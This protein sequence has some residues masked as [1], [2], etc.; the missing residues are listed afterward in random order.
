[1]KNRTIAVDLAKNVSRTN[2]VDLPFTS[3]CPISHAECHRRR[4]N[5][6][7]APT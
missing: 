7:V 5:R 2:A 1:M 4:S 3:E 6:R